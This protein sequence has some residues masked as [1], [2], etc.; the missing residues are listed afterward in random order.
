MQNQRMV[1]TNFS[2]VR[3]EALRQIYNAQLSD[4]CRYLSWIEN[5]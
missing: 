2:L 4:V 1:K 5:V 3:A